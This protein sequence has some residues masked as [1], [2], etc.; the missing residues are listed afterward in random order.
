VLS[1]RPFIRFELRS[2][3]YTASIGLALPVL[4]LFYVHEVAAPDAWIGVIGS[5]QSAGGVLGYV[6]ARQLARR[7]GAAMTLLPSMLAAALAPALLSVI[8]WLP[9][10][11]AISFVF[12]LAGASVQLAMFD[13][14]MRRLPSELAVTFSSV[15]QSVQNLA[16]VVAPNIGGLLSVVIGIRATLLVVALV[17]A[18]AFALFA[19]N[20]WQAVR[21]ASQEVTT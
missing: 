21:P 7:R 14:F 6:L 2:L 3:V 19:W 18:V 20:A 17:G 16:L 8:G 13:Q 10:V 4:P 11:A 15:D 5:A 9:A 12:G 1:N